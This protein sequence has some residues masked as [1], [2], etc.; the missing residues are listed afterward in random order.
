MIREN[1]EKQTKYWII[2]LSIFF[3]LFAAY[4]FFGG[5]NFEYPEIESTTV[6][7][8]DREKYNR[9]AQ[10]WCEDNPDKCKG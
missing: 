5:D 4:L 2:G 9:E 8:T 10:E 3:F 1:P 7:E 6:E